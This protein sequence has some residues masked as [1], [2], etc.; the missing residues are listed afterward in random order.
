MEEICRCQHHLDFSRWL[1]PVLVGEGEE[2][3]KGVEVGGGEH[4]GRPRGGDE[5]DKQGE[6]LSRLS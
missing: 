5:S 1:L 3:G 2:V 4:P 6:D